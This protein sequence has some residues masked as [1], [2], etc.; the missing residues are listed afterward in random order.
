MNLGIVEL[1]D[2]AARE[3]RK[4]ILNVIARNDR[5]NVPAGFTA[6]YLRDEFVQVVPDEILPQ[7]KELLIYGF[8]WDKSN[9]AIYGNTTSLFD[10]SKL[11]PEIIWEWL[12]WAEIQLRNDE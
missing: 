3:K 7:I 4:T 5:D 12:E 9:R 11:G 8:E 2:I 1:T 10:H 6:V